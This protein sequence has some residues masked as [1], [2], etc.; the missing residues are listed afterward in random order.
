[1]GRNHQQTAEKRS[2]LRILT[3]DPAKT[4]NKRLLLFD[5]DFYVGLAGLPRCASTAI[6]VGR[7]HNYI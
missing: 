1:M 4:T 5:L 7:Y 6:S 2:L 3:A